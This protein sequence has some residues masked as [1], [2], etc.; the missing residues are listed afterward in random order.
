MKHSYENDNAVSG[1]V[2]SVKKELR[3]L[4]DRSYI[5]YGVL[6]RQETRYK[7]QFKEKFVY[8]NFFRSDESKEIENLKEGD[9]IRVFIKVYSNESK[10]G[11]FYSNING[12]DFIMLVPAESKPA[13]TKQ[14]NT[15]TQNNVEEE[16]QDIP[17]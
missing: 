17:F 14:Q 3:E 16:S 1:D 5:N 8:I 2:V 7:D 9:N 13:E 6:L 15:I 12:S 10:N 11:G 4:G